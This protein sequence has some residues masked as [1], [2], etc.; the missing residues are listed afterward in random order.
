MVMVMMMM[1]MM[2]MMVMMMMYDGVQRTVTPP[3]SS[4]VL[5]RASSHNKKVPKNPSEQSRVKRKKMKT[6][7]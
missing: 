6:Q 1:M 2:M 5:L 4:L 3:F 7:L